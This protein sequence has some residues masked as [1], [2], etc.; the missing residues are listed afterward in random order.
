MEGTCY[1]YVGKCYYYFTFYHAIVKSHGFIYT[2]PLLW[3]LTYS[4]T[5][6]I[7]KLL[8]IWSNFVF[9]HISLFNYEVHIVIC[10]KMLTPIIQIGCLDIWFASTCKKNEMINAVERIGT[11]SFIFFIINENKVNWIMISQKYET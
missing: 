8:I 3:Q 7:F 9:G 11:L 6:F 5:A 2:N 1:C 10:L 4:I